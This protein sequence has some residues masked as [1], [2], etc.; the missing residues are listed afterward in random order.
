MIRSYCCAM[1][2]AVV[3]KIT[4]PFGTG[5]IVLFQ[6]SYDKDYH[7]FEMVPLLICGAFAVSKQGICPLL[8]LL[9]HIFS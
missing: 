5:K 2:A 6:V 9:T 8:C 3:L 7:L 1:V 4:D